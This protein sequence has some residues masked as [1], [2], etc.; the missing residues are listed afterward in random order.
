M[1]SL[2]TYSLP[3]SL[4]RRLQAVFDFPNGKITLIEIA[5]GTTVEQLRKVTGCKFDVSPNLTKMGQV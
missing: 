2:S 5:D 4:T 1:S 3:F